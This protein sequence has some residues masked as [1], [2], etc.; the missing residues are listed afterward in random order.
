MG[1]KIHSNNVYSL[2]QAMLLNIYPRM[3]HPQRL[4]ELQTC[5][6]DEN[7]KWKDSSIFFMEIFPIYQVVSQHL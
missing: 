6:F 7:K 3:Y 2:R 5:V 1:Q 4:V